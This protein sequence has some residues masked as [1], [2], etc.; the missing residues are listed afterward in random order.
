[1]WRTSTTC[2]IR[3]VSFTWESGTPPIVISPVNPLFFAEMIP[4]IVLFPH[5]DSPTRDTKLPAGRYKSIPFKISLSSSYAK[6]TL[7]KEISND[8]SGKIFSP[9]CGSGKSNILKILSLAAIPF[10]AIW[11]KDPKSLNGRKN[12]LARRTIHKVPE[13]LIFPFRNSDT[14]TAIPIAAPPYATMSI[15]LVEFSCMVRTF[16]V[17][18]RKF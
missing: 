1:M 18:L 13:M 12:S 11:K 10:I 8:P 3:S 14:A 17:I 2:L 15:T 16:M 5:P 9:V 6:C 4:A 7:L